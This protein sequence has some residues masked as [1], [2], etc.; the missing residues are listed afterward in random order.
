LRTAGRA[1]EAMPW[2]MGDYQSLPAGPKLNP[3]G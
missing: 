2:A 3:R 1:P